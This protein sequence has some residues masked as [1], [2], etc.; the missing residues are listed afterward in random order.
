METDPVIAA[1]IRALESLS[2]AVA[3]I[4]ALENVRCAARDA[5]ARGYFR[6]AEEAILRD[7][8]ARYLTARAGLLEIIDDL[9]PLARGRGDDEATQRRC[10]VV[11]YAAACLLVRGARTLVGELATD[12][13][14][15][16][17]LNEAS[18]SHRIPR[19]QYTRIY[20]SLTSPRNAW[21]LLEALEHAER[22]RDTIEALRPDAAIAP[23]LAVLDEAEAAVRVGMGDY[24]RARLRYR[25]HAWRRRH[26]SA[27]QQGFFAVF[28]ALGRVIADVRAPLRENRVTPAVR[29]ELASL[30]RPGDV[31][32]TR[33]DN[34]LSNLFLPGYWPHAALHVG[35]PLPRGDFGVELDRERA[36]RWVEPFRVLEARKDGV[37]LR[38]IDDTLAVDA[39]TVI[40]PRLEPPKIAEALRCALTHEGKLYNFDFDFFTDD[41][42]VCTEVVY[43]AYEGIGGI[44]FRLR[45]RA[46]RLTLSAEDLLDM[47]VEDRGFE[48]V[49]VFG[50]P[51]VGARLVTGGEAAAA[52]AESYREA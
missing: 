10:F 43:R 49:A 11:A 34:A 9:A 4:D 42:L 12:T 28:E 51:G 19:K 14:V 25:W 35:P 40:R 21:R 20:R 13:V 29:A 27:A 24:F 46:G 48:A 45:Q 8:F 3:R 38:A 37:R 5:A 41:R 30:L 16:R 18:D 47:A 26:A 2:P 44:E 23:A 39:F 7:W 52:L 1:G 50:T 31:V 15:Q 33:H 22:N 32:V 6:P 17:K 36:A